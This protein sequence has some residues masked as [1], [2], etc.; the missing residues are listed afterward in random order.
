MNQ[1]PQ[2]PPF[3][4]RAWEKYPT[5]Y[6]DEGH[7]NL[8]DD[9]ND[10]RNTSKTLAEELAACEEKEL[11]ANGLSRQKLI[12]STYSGLAIDPEK[13][14]KARIGKGFLRRVNPAKAADCQSYS[15]ESQGNGNGTVGKDK[16]TAGIYQNATNGEL[17]VSF[18]FGAGIQV[19]KSR[20]I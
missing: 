14:V 5:Y 17:Q 7:D 16:T 20:F 11:A 15:K 18:G 4:R 13:R 9:P 19:G 12:S 1:F 6:T 2:F 8:D 3:S 10:P